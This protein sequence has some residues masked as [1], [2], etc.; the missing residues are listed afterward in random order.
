MMKDK[1]NPVFGKMWNIKT[2]H[3]S[4][5]IIVPAGLEPNISGS[6]WSAVGWLTFGI[7]K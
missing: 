7:A 1:K 2:L 3:K 5:K 4:M 6:K